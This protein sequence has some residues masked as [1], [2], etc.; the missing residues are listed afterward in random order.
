M[1]KTIINEGLNYHDL[2]G[3]IEPIITVD[4]YE[5]KMGED[6]EIVTLAFTV[7]GE[8]VG[9]DLVDWF[10]HGYDWVLDAQVSDGEVS[11][12]K[13]LVFIEMNRRSKV[14]ERII[15]MLSDLQT[16]TNIPLKDWSVKV[17]DEEYDADEDILKQVIITSPHNYREKKEEK[18]EPELNNMRELSGLEPKL[19]EK[20][21]DAELKEYKAMAG[22]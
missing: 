19:P 13:Y 17:E 4:E 16:L 7:N 8:G 3:Q 9:N 14:P 1:N 11:P 15:E 2:E 22:L 18:E 12:R 5:A 20:E 6:S 10:E 21:Q